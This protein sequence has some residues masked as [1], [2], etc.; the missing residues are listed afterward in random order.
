M[1]SAS[2]KT[3]RR[4]TGDMPGQSASSPLMKI[5]GM[6]EV[7]GERIMMGVCGRVW[8]FRCMS[9]RGRPPGSGECDRRPVGVRA[10]S[11]GARSATASRL[12]RPQSLLDRR[13]PFPGAAGT[14]SPPTLSMAATAPT[15]VRGLG[16]D[17]GTHSR[18]FSV[19]Q[20]GL[21]HPSPR[22]RTL[23]GHDDERR[24]AAH[25][26]RTQDDRWH[27]QVQSATAGAGQAGSRAQQGGRHQ[28]LSER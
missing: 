12:L 21:T 8:A 28:G 25:Q 7:D 24:Q 14:G 1:K 5:S 23:R 27:A 11:R 13:C 15:G 20:P 10:P 26:R 18:N 2:E 16:G 19:R 17:A 6:D 3:A 4:V 9:W 22:A